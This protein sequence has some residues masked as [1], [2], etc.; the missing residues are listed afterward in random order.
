MF[1]ATIDFEFEVQPIALIQCRHASTFDGTDVNE[2]IGL[3]IIALD[4]TKALHAV[5]E[6]DRAA[7]L[8]TGELALR[9]T[10]ASF[11]LGNRQRV[12]IDDEIAC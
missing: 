1:A 10:A 4:E 11:T 12:T 8:F 7:R 9:S 6:F 5:E 3:A 2:S